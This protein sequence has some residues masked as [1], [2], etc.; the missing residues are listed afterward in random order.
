[1]LAHIRVKKTFALCVGRPNE[2]ERYIICKG[3]CIVSRTSVHV[4]RRLNGREMRIIGRS[5]FIGRNMRN[6]TWQD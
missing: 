4:T 3:T 1:M 6:L 2:K 5:K